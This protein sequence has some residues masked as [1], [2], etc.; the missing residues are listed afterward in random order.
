MCGIAGIRRLDGAPVDPAVLEAMA[1]TLTHR[2]PDGAGI[3][4][5]GPV[6]FAHRRLAIID[7]DASPQPMST[8]DGRLTVCF[9]G[10]ILNYRAL[11]AALPHRFRTHGDTEV[12]LALHDA[13]GPDGVHQ[14]VGQFAYALHDGPRRQLWL[15][16]DRLGIL[17]L[18]TYA[19]DRLVAFASE[20]KALLPALPHRPDVDPDSLDAYLAGRAVPAPW[21]LLQGIRKLPPGHRQL[22]DDRGVHPPQRW[23]QLPPAEAVH[24]IAPRTAVAATESALTRAVEACL[25]ADVPV[26]AYLSGGVDSSLVVALT[27]SLRPD[28]PLHTFAAGFAGAH[29]D[30]LPAARGVARLLRTDHHEVRVDPATFAADWRRLTWHRDAPL[31]EPADVAVHHLAVAA[32]DHVKVVLSG[33]GGDELFAG[34]PK[35]RLGHL[36]ALPPAALRQPAATWLDPRLPRRAGRLRILVR[37]MAAGS[38]EERHAA[39]FAP[40]TARERRALLGGAPPDRGWDGGHRPDGDRLRRMLV[41]DLDGW[42]PDNL[43]ERGDRM[44][45]AASVELRPPLLDHRV[46]ELAFTL[47]SALK[48]RRGRGKWLLREVARRHLPDAVVDRPKRGF[49]VPLDAWFRGALEPLAHDLLLGSGSVVGD[50]LDRRA[51]AALLRRHR[52]G[53]ADEQIRIWTLLGLELWHEVVVRGGAVPQA[54]GRATLSS[55]S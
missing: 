25:V 40:F 17:P 26:G 33:E 21:T 38:E 30:E 43:L 49:P 52:R 27:R 39:W 37:A 31:S 16:R 15:V 28:Q 4:V 13:A 36:A 50:L 48:V 2:G 12:L 51:I 54:A 10:E 8:A 18:Y 23:W 3:W 11:R 22:V 41:H 32:A 55:R 34:Y 19:D 5:E 14:L 47:P 6:G 9:N 45:M 20:V 46:V 44:T 42:L 7:P 24:P 29:V 35:H 1:A 53:E